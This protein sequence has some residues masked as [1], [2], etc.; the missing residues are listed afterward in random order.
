M[1]PDA[2]EIN[3]RRQRSGAQNRMYPPGLPINA[4]ARAALSAILVGYR[5]FDLVLF[6]PGVQLPAIRRARA[7]GVLDCPELHYVYS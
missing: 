7:V 1:S 6:P 5:G 2:V 3:I 4:G